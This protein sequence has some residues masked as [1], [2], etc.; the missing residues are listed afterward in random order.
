[1]LVRY[2]SAPLGVMLTCLIGL[3]LARA[4]IYTWVDVSGAVNISNLS[5]P[6]GVRV[7][8]VIQEKPQE[9]LAHEDVARNA[10]RQ[11]ELQAISDRIRR[12]ESELESAQ[13]PAP[14]QV[15][16]VPV[17]ASPVFPV[18]YQPN[19]APPASGGCDP[20]WAGCWGWWGSAFY[21]TTVVVVR[22]PK[23]PR[24]R[25]G[26]A[27]RLFPAHHHLRSMS[28]ETT[29]AGLQWPRRMQSG[30]LLR[31]AAGAESIKRFR[32]LD[33]RQPLAKRDRGFGG[34]SA[35]RLRA[36]NRWRRFKLAK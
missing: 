28:V 14:P 21:P 15:I 11:A 29:S 16:Y 19:I 3:Q 26:R 30:P 27:G 23:L 4:D 20:S 5:P 17:T 33:S 34:R 25:P 1:M 8:S 31:Q 35:G 2:C 24:H 7:I 18:Q 6:E 9:L 13:P 10:A 22:A 32:V 12:L 36:D